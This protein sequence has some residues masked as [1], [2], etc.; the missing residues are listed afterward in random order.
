MRGVEAVA[1]DCRVHDGRAVHGQRVALDDDGESGKDDRRLDVGHIRRDAQHLTAIHFF[2]LAP[3]RDD[4]S[5]GGAR[6]LDL[7]VEHIPG[8]ER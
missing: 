4:G 8:H 1:R 6:R 2:D 7:A 5:P 3:R